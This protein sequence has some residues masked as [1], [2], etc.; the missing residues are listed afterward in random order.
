LDASSSLDRSPL[1]PLRHRA[2]EVL[3]AVLCA[4]LSRLGTQRYAHPTATGR[5]T[6]PEPSYR[7]TVDTGETH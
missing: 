2:F 3:R 1:A 5:R 6:G 4:K 7:S